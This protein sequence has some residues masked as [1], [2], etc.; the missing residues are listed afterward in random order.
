MASSN[1]WVGPGYTWCKIIRWDPGEACV[2]DWAMIG[3][4]K[5][6][7]LDTESRYC[8][9]PERGIYCV[10]CEVSANKVDRPCMAQHRGRSLYTSWRD[11]VDCYLLKMAVAPW[12]R[13]TGDRAAWKEV[14]RE[15]KGHPKLKRR[16]K[17]KWEKNAHE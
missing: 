3:K 13:K 10:L 16:K 7:C 12:Q 2:H 11:E 1:V 5:C 6:D 4:G 8:P 17:E 14:V 9:D 15:P